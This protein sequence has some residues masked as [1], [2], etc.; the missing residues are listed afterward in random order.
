MVSNILT[1]IL[2]EFNEFNTDTKG[3]PQAEWY[4]ADLN[5]IVHKGDEKNPVQDQILVSSKTGR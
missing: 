1:R 3:S 5:Y 2:E 4:S